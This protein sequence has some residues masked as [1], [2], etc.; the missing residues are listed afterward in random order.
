MYQSITKFVVQVELMNKVL[1]IYILCKGI[2]RLNY[3]N[4]RITI[5]CSN[6]HNTSVPVPSK[7]MESKKKHLI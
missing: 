2:I 7:M 5:K 1:K 4:T 6:Y 3:Q